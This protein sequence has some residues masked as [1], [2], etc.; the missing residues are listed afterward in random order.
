MQKVNHAN[1]TPSSFL[2]KMSD[3]YPP[4]VLIYMQN[5]RHALFKPIIQGKERRWIRSLLLP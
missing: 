4:F 5:P 1:K 3:C 2:A